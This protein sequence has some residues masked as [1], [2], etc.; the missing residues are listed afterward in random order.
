MDFIVFFERFTFPTYII[1]VTVAVEIIKALAKPRINPKWIT[2]AVAL[3]AA[4]VQIVYDDTAT[5]DSWW[6]LL[7]SFGIAVLG[8]DY[9]LKPIKDLIGKGKV[10]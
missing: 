10:E 5:V 8:Y 1:A 3:L 9:F 2:L 6:K 4:I 7:I